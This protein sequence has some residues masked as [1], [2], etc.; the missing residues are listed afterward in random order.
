MTDS[1]PP[2]VAVAAAPPL[3]AILK[4]TYRCNSRC[5]F[6]R[7]DGPRHAVPDVP[8]E[9]VARKMAKAK[10]LG[11]EMVLFSGGEPTLRD[12]LPVLAKAATALGLRWGLVS[13]GRRLAYEVYREGL[14]DLGLAYLHTSLHGARTQT[15]NT[16]AQC[17][18]MGQVLAAL[19]GLARRGIELAV[20]TVIS[21]EN[22]DELAGISDLL[23]Q[24][25]P[26]EH[27]L[28]LMEPSGRSLHH[29]A[30]LMLPPHEAAAL[31]VAELVR[32]NG[33]WGHA[34][35]RT[36]LEGFPLC[37]VEGAGDALSGLQGHNIRWMSEAFED[38]LYPTDQGDRT[39]P[40]AC[41]GCSLRPSCPGVYVG[42]AERF[43]SEGLKP[44]P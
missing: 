14:V 39:F 21:R 18:G 8:A 5:L 30:R 29:A 22:A 2:E 38:E 43:G 33:L 11:A 24:W 44:R 36:V 40:D 15:H 23:A 31:A 10:A 1:P 16:L 41:T 17:S 20:N 27:K 32:S 12:D 7:A 35:L 26:L 9:D 6:C 3:R 28:C 4:L 19:D 34:G 13:N 25:A 42:Y 37:Q